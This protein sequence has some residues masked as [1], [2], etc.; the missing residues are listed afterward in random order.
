MSGQ[1]VD[2]TDGLGCRELGG[3]FPFNPTLTMAAHEQVSSVDL[4]RVQ[5][6]LL[7]WHCHPW[8]PF[9]SVDLPSL[10]ALPSHLFLWPFGVLGSVGGGEPQKRLPQ[11][12]AK[13][14]ALDCPSCLLE[15][16]KSQNDMTSE[17]HL[18]AMDPRQCVGHTERRSQS[19]TAVNVTSRVGAEA[20]ETT[21]HVHAIFHECPGLFLF[22]PAFTFLLIENLN[23][24]GKP[25]YIQSIFRH[26][27]PKEA[28]N[29]SPQSDAIVYACIPSYWAG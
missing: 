16:S 27:K 18:L 7:L 19:D 17:K 15:L 4:G 10:P 23:Q 3:R 5:P 8:S 14:V 29:L 6:S 28:Q 21:D 24:P 22:F 9:F 25:N 13:L 26:T 1:A 12:L 2:H 20:T 11:V